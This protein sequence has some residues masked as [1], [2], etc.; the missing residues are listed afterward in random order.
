MTNQKYTYRELIEAH[1]RGEIVEYWNATEEHWQDYH[2]HGI[3]AIR[4]IDEEAN[5]LRLKPKTR[6]VRYCNGVEL[7][8]CETKQLKMW[9]PYYSP[10]IYS[11]SGISTHVWGHHE[12]DFVLLKNGL[13]YLEK[14]DAKV[15]LDALLSVEI[16]EIEG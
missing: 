5:G 8:Q 7:P 3:C 14:A 10:C 16:R 2:W 11:E 1:L 12:T 15:H 4:D 13:I 6:T 9:T